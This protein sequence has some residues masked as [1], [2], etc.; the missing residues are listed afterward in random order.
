ME[1][2]QEDLDRLLL[3]DQFSATKALDVLME[4]AQSVKLLGVETLGDTKAYHIHF[5][6]EQIPDWDLWIQEGNQPLV[7]KI[8]QEGEQKK[9]GASVKVTV[10]TQFNDW[11]INVPIP[12]ERFAF[13]PPQNAKKVAELVK[14]PPNPMLLVGQPAPSVKLK[15]LDGTVVDL[16]SFK[17]KNVV[18]LDF[19]A[20]WCGPCRMAMPVISEVAATYKDK[21]LI[22]YAVNLGEDLEKLQAFKKA[23]PALTMP[24]LMDEDTKTA[25]AY[26]IVSIPMTVIIG[27]DG[28]I[29]RIHKDVPRDMDVLRKRLKDE[30]D[31]VL[32]GGSLLT[33]PAK[34]PAA[35]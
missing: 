18:I 14:H 26:L 6:L 20:T 10:T 32:G 33:P 22:A 11:K 4:G 29:Q 27:K 12:K 16:A 15:L 5:T 21:G 7:L 3:L 28:V 1:L 25:E 2:I 24:I 23:T 13:T 31:T 17:G 35:K 34:E 19:W 9:N 8:S 30:F